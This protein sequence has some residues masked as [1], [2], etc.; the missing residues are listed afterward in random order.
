LAWHC[1]IEHERVVVE[2]ELEAASE[3]LDHRQ[4]AGLPVPDAMELA[5]RT[6]KARTARANTPER[7]AVQ[8]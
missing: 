5:M 1:A 8:A 3:A 4:L 7:G 6:W 2:V